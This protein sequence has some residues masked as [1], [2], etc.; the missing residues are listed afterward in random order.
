MSIKFK[1]R[2]LLTLFLSK[3]FEPHGMC[4]N[5]LIEL[6]SM[7]GIIASGT[8]RKKMAERNKE[9][10]G[11][12][13]GPPSRASPCF[14]PIQGP[15]PYISCA[16]FSP[17]ALFNWTPA[18]SNKVLV[19]HSKIETGSFQGRCRFDRINL[20]HFSTLLSYV[21]NILVSKENFRFHNRITTS[22]LPLLPV[23]FFKE[24]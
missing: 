2:S 3:Q 12:V 1:W 24:K 19:N 4:Q 20:P 14:S 21:S 8:A 11:L 5:M 16:I 18:E 23:F 6:K 10:R 7:R 17:C 15:C 9:E 13:R 22:D